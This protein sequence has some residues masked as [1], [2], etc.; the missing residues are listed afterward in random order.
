VGVVLL[1]LL[2]LNS[3]D[4]VFLIAKIIPVFYAGV[5]LGL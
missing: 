4:F 1:L 3:E 2:L 5:K